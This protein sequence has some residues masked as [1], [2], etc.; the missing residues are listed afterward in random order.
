MRD[1]TTIIAGW[2]GG[3]LFVAAAFGGTWLHGYTR[4]QAVV[5]AEWAEATLIAERA[6]RQTEQDLAEMSRKAAGRLSERMRLLDEQAKRQQQA[7]HRSMAALRDRTIPAPV[8]VQLDQAS[9][10]SKPTAVADGV[11]A[12]ADVAAL[13]AVIGLADTL[14]IVRANYQICNANSERFMAAE[15]WY[16]ALRERINEGST[17]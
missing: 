13:D 16:S 7:W 3:L 10:V 4:G 17:P 15:N 12:G 2:A 5:R 9:G 8:G 14:D 11:Q 6:A 1:I